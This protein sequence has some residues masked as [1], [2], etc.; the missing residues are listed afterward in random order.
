MLSNKNVHEIADKLGLWNKLGITDE[1]PKDRLTLAIH[2]IT[3]GVLRLVS[4][5]LKPLMHG[6]DRIG[7]L[8]RNTPSKDL[9][10]ALREL[11]Y[12]VFTYDERTNV[13][14]SSEILANPTTMALYLR[15]LV[16]SYHHK[17]HNITITVSNLANNLVGDQSKDLDR[18]HG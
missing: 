1:D 7:L 15:L 2:K 14:A 6:S 17:V 5:A 12:A 16:M 11:L 18:I 4:F 8:F 10:P 3:G 13:L 9:K